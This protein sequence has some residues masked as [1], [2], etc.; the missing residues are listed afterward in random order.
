MY[1]EDHHEI[2][3]LTK[4][5]A[6]DKITR[7]EVDVSSGMYAEAERCI[8]GFGRQSWPKENTWKT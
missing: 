5:N 4:H 7:N 8:W 2:L 6:G 3:R 1:N